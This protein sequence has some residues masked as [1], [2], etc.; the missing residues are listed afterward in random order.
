MQ[1]AS[2]EHCLSCLIVVRDLSCTILQCE[3]SI[4]TEECGYCL[5][6]LYSCE[7]YLGCVHSRRCFFNV[8]EVA[9]LVSTLSHI[10]SHFSYLSLKPLIPH[11]PA[12]LLFTLPITISNYGRQ[13]SHASRTSFLQHQVGTYP[14]HPN[15]WWTSRGPEDQEDDQGTTMLRLQMLIAWD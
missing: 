2:F 6:A 8:F 15:T 7:I 3:W 1:A 11:I 10:F 4:T 14:Y 5:L 9:L 13:Q 12:H